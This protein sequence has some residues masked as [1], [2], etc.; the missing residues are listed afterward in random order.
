MDKLLTVSIAA[1][2]VEK[3]IKQTLMH[4]LENR[5]ISNSLL[6]EIEVLII[7]DGSTDNTVQLAKQYE[8]KYPHIIKV[9]SK[10][11]GGHGST[12]NTG[13]RV[14][15]G[16]YFK[17]LDGDDWFDEYGLFLV[18]KCLE[19]ADSDMIITDFMKC[20][21][22]G[23]FVPV[24][25]KGINSLIDRKE[26]DFDEIINQIQWIPYHA[27]IYKTSI[28]Q[29]YNIQIDEKSFYVDTEF[30]L[31]PI[32]FI[33]SL[34]YVN[35]CLYCYRLGLEGQSVSKES[36]IK[37]IAD[38]RKVADALLIMYQE[39][40]ANFSSEKRNYIIRGIG[41]HCVWHYRSSLLLQANKKTKGDLIMF[42]KRIKSVSEG[43]YCYM[44]ETSSLVYWMRKSHY[45]LYKLIC[46]YRQHNRE[47]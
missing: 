34:M 15:S 17:A 46:F 40:K 24:Q 36:R 3:Y 44:E 22:N 5:Y 11:N 23:H 7:D 13:I 31:Y 41:G 21:E 6:S 47:K 9:I 4:I 30:M 14:A 8:E 38:G 20:Y 16:K 37:N 1:Y 29:D 35:C 25:I 32:P 45:C 18:L 12:I 19:N 27:A 42:D 28:L 39:Q 26:Y 43:I 10:E 2:N 33:Q